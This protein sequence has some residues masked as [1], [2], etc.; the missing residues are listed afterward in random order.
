[1]KAFRLGDL[2]E[3]FL[4][5]IAPQLGLTKQEIQINTTGLVVGEKLH[6]DLISNSEYTRLYE[7][8]H[9][10]IILPYN[11]PVNK[12]SGIRKVNLLRYNSNDVALLS[13]A[14]IEDIINE[15]LKNR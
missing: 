15:H 4:D 8:E 9:M 14:E 6:E 11:E 2:L 12:Y 5:K 13:K 3:V 10:Y 1:M 7:T